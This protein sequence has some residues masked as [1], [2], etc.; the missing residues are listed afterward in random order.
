[1]ESLD[2][3]F[4]GCKKIATQ[5]GVERKEILEILAKNLIKQKYNVKIKPFANILD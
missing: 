3:D 2:I 1:M 5:V 4:D